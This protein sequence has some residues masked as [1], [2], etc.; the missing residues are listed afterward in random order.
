[1]LK[2][3]RIENRTLLDNVKLQSCA[4]CGIEA[5]PPDRLNDPHHVTTVRAGG[6]DVEDNVMPLC[7]DHH[8]QWHAPFKGPS[9]LINEFPKVGEWLFWHGRS[10]VMQRIRRGGNLK[11]SG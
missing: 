5:F 2:T 8:K 10:D 7:R 1:M 11:Y 4:A 9:S 3:K 6:G